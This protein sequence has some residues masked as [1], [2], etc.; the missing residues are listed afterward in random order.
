MYKLI[1]DEHGSFNNHRD[2]DLKDAFQYIQ[3]LGK[4]GNLSI[5][6]DGLDELGSLT[7]KES[8]DAGGVALH[9][10]KEIYMKTL[11]VGILRQKILPGA[12]VVATGRNTGA[13]NTQNIRVQARAGCHG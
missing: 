13:V 5:W 11:F 1:W 3:E 9:P 12:R 6:I 8:N 7:K 2:T 10:N 4:T